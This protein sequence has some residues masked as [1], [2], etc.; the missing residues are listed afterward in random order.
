[1]S[2]LLFVSVGLNDQILKAKQHAEQYKAISG[3]IE[4][5]LK[6]QNAA[7]QT[8]KESMEKRLQEAIQGKLVRFQG[9][10]F[11]ENLRT[12]SFKSCSKEIIT[13]RADILEIM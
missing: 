5:S 9:F 12:G 11:G 7:S 2:I 1:M 10:N 13:F 3:A 6:E 4:E 8:F